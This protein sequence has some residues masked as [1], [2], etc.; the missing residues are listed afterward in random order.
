MINL[1]KPILTLVAKPAK[2]FPCAGI[3]VKT[4]IRSGAWRCTDCE[5]QA[6]GSDPIKPNCDYCELA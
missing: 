6:V 2:N 3:H 4:G 1:K 5:G